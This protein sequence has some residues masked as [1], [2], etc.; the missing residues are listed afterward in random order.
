MLDGL[1]DEYR[2]E[3]EGA[4][5]GTSPEWDGDSRHQRLFLSVAELLRIASSSEGA[6]LV[7]DDAHDA[8]EASMR[9]LHYL[10][11]LAVGERIVIVIAHR[12][13]PLRPAMD[14]M[15]RSLIGRGTSVPL[16]LGPLAD[17]DIRR[18]ARRTVRRR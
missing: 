16:D 5:R 18:L 11:R 17:E 15:R 10:S 12:P 8:D 2:V 3:I 7:V 13:W 14:A 4:L 9:L 6:V 1:A